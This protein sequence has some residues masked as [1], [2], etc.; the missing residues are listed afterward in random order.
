M[1]RG[2]PITIQKC[3]HLLLSMKLKSFYLIYS[4][5]TFL[6]MTQIYLILQPSRVPG[7]MDHFNECK[8]VICY[9]DKITNYHISLHVK[10]GIV[11]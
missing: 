9:S 2:F 7:K 11:V 10:L 6:K 4:S 3:W 5:L 8:I 1:Y